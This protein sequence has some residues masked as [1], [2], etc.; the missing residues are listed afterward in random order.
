MVWLLTRTDVATII[1]ARNRL[2]EVESKLELADDRNYPTGRLAEAC[3]VADDALLMILILAMVHNL[4][5]T[6][7][8]LRGP[9]V[10]GR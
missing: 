9:L 4:G 6:D 10:A 1:R 2:A 7:A 8:E 3:R 5:V